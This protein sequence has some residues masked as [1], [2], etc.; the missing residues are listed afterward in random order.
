M[1]N[2]IKGEVPLKLEDGRLLT[3]VL[4][5]EAF[6]EAETAYGKPLQQVMADASAGFVG[7]TRALLYGALQAKHPNISLRDASTMFQTDREA[8]AV[9]LESAAEAAFPKSTAE[10][11]EGNGRPA[12][13]NSGANG[14]KRASTRKPSGKQPP[15]PSA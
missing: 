15:A 6:V 5:M 7:A 13:K 10:S 12:G 8:V 1:A 14:A 4:D 11:A 3:L 2:V 9:A